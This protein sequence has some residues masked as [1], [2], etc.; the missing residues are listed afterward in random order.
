[1][2]SRSSKLKRYVIRVKPPDCAKCVRVI[3]KELTGIEEAKLV[4][5]DP[6]TGKI[7]IY[8]NPEKVSIE[9][10][11][12]IVKKTGKTPYMIEER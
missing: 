8:V 5:V 11:L 3:E 2:S 1:L 12:D 7:V 4:G 9:K 10:L 6:L